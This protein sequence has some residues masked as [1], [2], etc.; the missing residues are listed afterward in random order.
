ME[1]S[2]L[3]ESYQ[4]YQVYV[5]PKSNDKQPITVPLNEFVYGAITNKDIND[6]F[7]VVLPTSVQT[8]AIDFQSEMCS[9]YRSQGTT[10]PTST[11]N[12]G[13][14]TGKGMDSFKTFEVE[15]SQQQTFA[16]VC[17]DLYNVDQSKYK[18]RISKK[19]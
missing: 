1:E 14:V 5:N 9:L 15:G 19:T 7:T 8:Y 6:Y 4:H 12:Q 17:N 18:F 2:N 11:V 10:K 3:A 16:V 13:Y